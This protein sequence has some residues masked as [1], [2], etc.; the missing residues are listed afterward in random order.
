MLMLWSH[1]ASSSTSHCNTCHVPS[2][3]TLECM[4]RSTSEPLNIIF[5]DRSLAISCRQC[6]GTCKFHVAS[7][8]ELQ[9]LPVCRAD[10]WFAL[11]QETL[12]ATSTPAVEMLPV[13]APVARAWVAALSRVH[14]GG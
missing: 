2:N 5:A 14:G 9:G 4:Q 13:A 7:D 1:A 3:R 12:T 8:V 6:R 10:C 11:L